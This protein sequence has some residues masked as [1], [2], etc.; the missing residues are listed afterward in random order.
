[1]RESKVQ[2]SVLPRI[3]TSHCT[4][5]HRVL[6]YTSHCTAHVLH[7]TPY[8]PVLHSSTL[9]CPVLY[10][11]YTLHQVTQQADS[12]VVSYYTGLESMKAAVMEARKLSNLEA[13]KLSNF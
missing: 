3:C 9:Y 6:H 7:C 1:M 8:H 2:E 4:L 11:Y 12:P 13:W 10:K 5:Y